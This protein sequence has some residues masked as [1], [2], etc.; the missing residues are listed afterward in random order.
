MAQ[1]Q[2]YPHPLGVLPQFNA[3]QLTTLVLKEKMFSLTG[4]GFYIKTVDGQ[5][6]LKVKP[7]VFSLSHR[8]EISDPQG[9]PLFT[10]RAEHFSIPRSYYLENPQGQKFLQVQGKFS[11]MLHLIPLSMFV[12]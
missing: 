10:I 4:D 5:E 11:C 7:E 8:K 2:P 1:L 3:K 12:I 9:N 6:L